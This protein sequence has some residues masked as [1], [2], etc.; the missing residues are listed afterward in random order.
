MCAPMA[1]AMMQVR[2]M[3]VP[4]DPRGMPMPMHMRLA[5]GV[6]GGVFVLVMLVM[7]MS[8]LVF[9]GFVDVLVFMLFRQVQP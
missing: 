9:H 4:V 6:A 1:V 3:R 7:V 8:V 5:H 2:V